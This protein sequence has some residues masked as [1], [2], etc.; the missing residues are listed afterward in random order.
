[1]SEGAPFTIQGRGR[2]C[3][4]AGGLQIRVPFCLTPVWQPRSVNV[5]YFGL[6]LG[7]DAG[8]GFPQNP[9]LPTMNA[10]L[11]SFPLSLVSV[12]GAGTRLGQDGE[13]LRRR[14][15]SV[16][17][18]PH[19]LKETLHFLHEMPHPLKGTPHFLHEMRHPLKGTPHFLHEIL[20]PLKEMP[21]FLH[22]M[23]HPLKE[24]PHFLHEM[25]HPLKG[26]PLFLHEM[27]HPLKEM[28]HSL[29]VVAHFLNHLPTPSPCQHR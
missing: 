23:P 17:E 21:H 1:M 15:F 25:P 4:D 13:R 9:F 24:T 10:L 16:E 19:P 29:Q 7:T 8:V 18:M 12:Q 3:Y 26:T 11:P 6:T 2:P 22:E 27:R 14:G 28:P 20:H 5:R